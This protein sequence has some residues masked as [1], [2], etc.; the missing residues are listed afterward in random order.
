MAVFWHVTL[1]NLVVRCY[2]FGGGRV[3]CDYISAKLY[4]VIFYF[5]TCTL[6]PLL[7]FV[8]T[9]KCTINIIKFDIQRTVHR[10]IFL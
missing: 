10:D 2:W 7:F 4:S 8:T 6:H 9:N 1:C 5:I 3:C